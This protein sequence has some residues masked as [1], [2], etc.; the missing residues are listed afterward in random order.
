METPTAKVD[1]SNNTNEEEISQPLLK[2]Q[3]S[4]L[5]LLPTIDQYHEQLQMLILALNHSVLSLVLLS[6]FG[7]P[8]TWLSLV[9][10][11]IVFN[12]TT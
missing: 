4:N 7:V 6:S 9:G 12:K 5:C 2:I 8:M 10:S 1:P 11:T 3:I